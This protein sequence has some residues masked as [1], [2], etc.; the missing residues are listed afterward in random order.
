MIVSKI[1]IIGGIFCVFIY[2]GFYALHIFIE[3][4]VWKKWRKEF[5][6]I[7]LFI[8]H[9]LYLVAAYILSALISEYFNF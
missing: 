4:Y 2:W 3:N 1:P 8:S 9:F 7:Y 5:S 6:I